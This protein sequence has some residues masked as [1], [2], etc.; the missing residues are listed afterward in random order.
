M[1]H[2]QAVRQYLAYWFQAGKRL[3]IKNKQDSY[4]PR[5][6][7]QGD[8]YSPEFEACWEYLT[9]EKPGECYL[10]GTDQTIQDLLS[11][12]WDVVSCARCDMPI[13]MRVVGR[14]PTEC[15]CFDLPTWPNTDIPQPRSP[16]NTI[17]QL[18]ELRNRL[19]TKTS[20]RPNS[21]E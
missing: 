7:I 21:E 10:E 9:S 20:D 3:R 16:I 8:R 18:S 1:A 15:P 17:S 19:M 2:E 4:A 11:E 12:Q 14:T 13:P 6:V 5:S